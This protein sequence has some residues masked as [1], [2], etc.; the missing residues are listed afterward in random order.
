M[1][2]TPHLVQPAELF[3]A[4]AAVVRFGHRD[5]QVVALPGFA[6]E[7]FRP[8]C[9][10]RQ[11]PRRQHIHVGVPPV[12]PRDFGRITIHPVVQEPLA[13]EV[14]VDP[15]N[16]GRARVLAEPGQLSLLDASALPQP[17]PH[18]MVRRETTGQQVETDPT[19]LVFE[20][21]LIRQCRGAESLAEVIGLDKAGARVDLPD[22][23]HRQH[24]RAALDEQRLR[25]GPMVATVRVP[26]PVEGAE[27]RRGQ[28]LVDWRVVLDPGVPLRYC[29]GVPGELLWKRWVQQARMRWAAAMVDEADDWPHAEFA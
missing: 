14:R 28:R 29:P 2:A 20:I 9:T 5:R 7:R 16:I 13:A 25:K 23:P 3:L 8:R 18:Q 11:D 6:K 10:L 22:C 1:G 19:S 26:V 27:S 4:G 17:T 12:R 21:R 15:D 24:H